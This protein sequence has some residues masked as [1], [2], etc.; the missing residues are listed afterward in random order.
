LVTWKLKAF[1]P[2]FRNSLSFLP[3]GDQPRYLVFLSP[4]FRSGSLLSPPRSPPSSFPS[5]L[6]S[7]GVQRRQ[8]S[9]AE[10]RVLPSSSSTNLL[11]VSRTLGYLLERFL[12][13]K[14]FRER[15]S[16]KFPRSVVYFLSWSPS[17]LF[18]TAGG[19]PVLLSVLALPPPIC[20]PRLLDQLG[21]NA[22][23][24]FFFY[25]SGV[26]VFLFIRS[27]YF[28]TVWLGGG[29]GFSFYL[30]V[31]YGRPFLMFW[32]ALSSFRW[33]ERDFFLDLPG[34]S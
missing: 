33:A 2:S 26:I 24:Y 8:C 22:H 20:S 23:A 3:V 13:L 9:S 17:H 11:S 1:S 7:A 19:S 12:F 14:K 16:T 18:K 15:S 10:T 25:S 30:A 28:L 32:D 4:A 6:Y 31:P 34:L 29:G 21:T 5:S 27:R